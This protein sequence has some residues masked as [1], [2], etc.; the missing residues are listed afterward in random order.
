MLFLSVQAIFYKKYS[1]LS[2]VWSYGCVVY[3][4]WS[5]GHKPFEDDNARAVR[6]SIVH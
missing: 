6:S 5:M 1:V 4:I 2:D 3:E